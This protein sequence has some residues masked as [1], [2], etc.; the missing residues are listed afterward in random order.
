MARSISSWDEIR[1]PYLGNCFVTPEGSGAS[2]AQLYGTGN[3]TMRGYGG[4]R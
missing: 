3:R 1:H 2:D 4:E